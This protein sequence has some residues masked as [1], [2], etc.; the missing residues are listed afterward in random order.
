MLLEADLEVVYKDMKLGFLAG[1]TDH[2]TREVRE[3]FKGEPGTPL[4]CI[5]LIGSGCTPSRSGLPARLGERGQGAK[6]SVDAGRIRKVQVPL[7]PPGVAF[8]VYQR[9]RSIFDNSH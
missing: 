6:A 4:H 7:Q 5:Q 9:S 3:I 8:G 2:G 1:D